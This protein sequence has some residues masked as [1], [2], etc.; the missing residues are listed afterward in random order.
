MMERTPMFDILLPETDDRPIYLQLY[1][2]IRTLI[3]DGS[4]P[5]GARL[6]SVRALRQQLNISK[7]PIENAYQMLTAEGY[8]VS[9]PRSG[10]Y[11]SNPPP[12]SSTTSGGISPPVQSG[13]GPAADASFAGLID[14]DPTRLDHGAFPLRI[15]QKMLRDALDNN[16][17]RLGGYGD[18][19][20]EPGLRQS[21]AEY[22]GSARG[23]QCVPDQIVVGSGMAYSIGI[24][25]K[26]LAGRRRVAMEEP[27]YNLVRDQLLL[28]GCEVQP[29]PV[30]DKGLRLDALA[31]ADVQAVYITPSHQFP[32]GSIMPYPERER[33]LVWA[34]AKDA[35]VIEDDYDGEF[36]YVGKPIPSL[37]GLDMHARVIYIGTFSKAFTPAVRLNYMVL[38]PALC[39]RLARMP[40]EV[41]HAPSRV[42]QWAMQSFISQGHWFRHVRKMRSLYRKR[43]RH[44]IE[45]IQSLL[46]DR[47]EVT[48][49]NAGLHLQLTV[50]GGSSAERLV[51]AA[52]SVGVKVYD[53]RKMWADQRQP[54][55]VAPKLYFGFAS[56][57][58]EEM[59][60]GIRLLAKAWGEEL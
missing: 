22:L 10:L 42:E 25:A 20:G 50:K 51:E 6:P 46:G 14:F 57:R 53:L 30:G 7:T 40:H 9:R 56:L 11:A 32:T 31:A 12:A 34:K 39:E 37:Q 29:V 35:Y 41:L 52:A 4:I 26:L 47:V 49:Q 2:Q 44:L 43:H 16:S 48:G 5:D 55:S 33:L 59:E 21:I 60:A 36:R 15:W 3:R 24:V 45:L 19:R 27:G 38:P 1:A 18:P 13:I 54:A 8:A 17:G 28:G 23:V 58:P